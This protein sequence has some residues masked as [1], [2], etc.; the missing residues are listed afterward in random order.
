MLDLSMQPTGWFQIAWSDELPA[1][2]V[3][4]LRYFGHEL[5]AFR[6]DVGE[7]A[8]LDAHCRH[9]GAH[10]GYESS[11]IDG[12]VQCPYHGWRWA[13]DGSNASIP[14]QDQP[15]RARLRRWDVVERHG[16]VFLWHDPAGDPPRPGWELPDLFTTIADVPGAEADYHPCFPNAVVDKPDEPIHPQLIQENAPDSMHFRFTHGAPEDPVFLGFETDGPLWR[17]SIGFR[18]PKTKQLALTLYNVNPGVG[19]SY[20][21]FHGANTHYRLILSA[22]PIDEGRSHLRVSYFLPR[23]EES[24][25]A[26]TDAQKAFAHHT[27]ELFEQ[28]ARI[29]RRQVFVQKPVFARQ[30]LAG[31]TA[32][33]RWSEQFYEA[34]LGPT[35]TPWV[36]E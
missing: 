13:S 29:W 27:I 4:A 32:L 10:L 24:P 21:M 34:P 22:T 11:V 28:D 3:K 16:L 15:S 5:V 18:S 14:Y 30:D 33:R 31:Y 36:M 20:A 17:S 25:L 1:G 7:L 23:L 2:T 6:S 35:P 12:C 9:L 19:L 26:M 8:V